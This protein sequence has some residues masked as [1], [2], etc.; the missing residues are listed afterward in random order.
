MERIQVKAAHRI[1]IARE[2]NGNGAY[3]SEFDRQSARIL[4]ARSTEPGTAMA[5]FSMQAI[6]YRRTIQVVLIADAGTAS[7]LV[8]D[9]DDGSHQSKTM[10]VRQYLDA[11]MTDEGV[12]RHVLNVVAAAIER[13]GQRWTH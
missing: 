11:G 12:A 9:N 6:L 1:R 2:T 8:V 4:E 13:R 5:T 3:I 10:K 7:I